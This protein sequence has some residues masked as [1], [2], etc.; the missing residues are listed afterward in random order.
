MKRTRVEARTAQ[1][2]EGLAAW[3]EREDARLDEHERD[4]DRVRALR[5]KAIAKDLREKRVPPRG[6][7][8]QHTDDAKHKAKLATRKALLEPDFE[9]TI[10]ATLLNWADPPTGEEGKHRPREKI[11]TRFRDEREALRWWY[12]AFAPVRS[13]HALRNFDKVALGATIQSSTRNVEP[14]L[15]EAARAVDRA[16]RNV[17]DND[18]RWLVWTYVEL[19]PPRQDRKRDE[20]PES[21][22]RV[23]IPIR[24]GEESRSAVAIAYEQKM[25]VEKGL[26]EPL[27]DGYGWALLVAQRAGMRLDAPVLRRWNLRLVERRVKRARKALRFALCRVRLEDGRTL[28]PVD[29]RD[30][31]RVTLPCC[32][33][34][35]IANGVRL[36][37]RAPVLVEGPEGAHP[38][39]AWPRC[40]VCR[41]PIVSERR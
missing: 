40:D 25:L 22:G 18:A 4:L 23:T 35:R 36:P 19:E 20:A 10:F 32:P 27:P 39:D 7:R 38:A 13:G 28:V 12:F 30:L 21:G 1:E 26:H 15:D 29:A 11:T 8:W 3:R 24:A 31:P 16:L 6:Q 41:L 37:C 9:R 2:T 34:V 17:S 5:E 33:G 14:Y